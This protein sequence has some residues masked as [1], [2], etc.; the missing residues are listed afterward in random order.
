MA[1][2]K[3]ST[4]YVSGGVVSTIPFKPEKVKSY[5]AGV[6]ADL[7][8]RRLRLNLAGFIAEYKDL[9]SV[10]AGVFLNRPELGL[11]VITEGDLTTK[12]L[13]LEATAAPV[14]G[15]TLSGGFGYTH[16]GKEKN[17]NPILLAIGFAQLQLRAK[18]TA[19]LAAQYETPPLFGDARIMARIDGS[20]RSKKVLYGTAPIPAEYEV[21]HYTAGGWVLNTRVAL[22]DIA[23]GGASLEIAGWARNLTDQDRPAYGVNFAYAGALTYEPAR[24]YGVDVTLKF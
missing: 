15:L 23:I 12:G 11:V 13:E 14:N 2:A 4:G 18:Y 5:E 6:K 7:L 21:M 22:R 3:F 19:N 1:Y 9:Q 8:D 10:Q 20:Y 16:L 24:T 17:V